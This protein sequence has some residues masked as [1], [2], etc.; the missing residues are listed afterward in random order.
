MGLS[1]DDQRA[2]LS[3]LAAS[4]ACFSAVAQLHVETYYEPSGVRG[5]PEEARRC[6][7][8]LA[9]CMANDELLFDDTRLRREV[10]DSL[11]DYL[12]GKG[13]LRDSRGRS[14]CQAAEKLLIFLYICGQG[15]SFRNARGRSGHSLE[16]ISR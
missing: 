12:V 5:R 6:R 13:W 14:S 7:E 2:A 10:W 16:T 9:A 11:L 1:D 8:W 15:A 4:L 3:G